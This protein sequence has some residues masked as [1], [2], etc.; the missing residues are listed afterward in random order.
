MYTVTMDV[1]FKA[2]LEN[3]RGQRDSAAAA[4]ARL[5]GDLESAKTRLSHLE[6]A[7]DNLEALTGD[8]DERKAAAPP[9]TA[10]PPVT[11]R[12]SHLPETTP[13]TS[14]S[15]RIPSTE[16]VAKIVNDF[17]RVVSRNEVFK[18]FERRYGIPTTW[19][20]PRNSLGNA[21]NRAADRG[22]IQR[23][24]AQRFAPHN[25]IGGHHDPNFGGVR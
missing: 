8:A 10:T 6:G 18:E 3:L 7:I 23:L 11:P 20:S 25:Y 12:E 9:I 5:T 16:L 24:D 2:T 13:P 19:V 22:W 21:I 1:D 15:R 4:V 17:D 14:R